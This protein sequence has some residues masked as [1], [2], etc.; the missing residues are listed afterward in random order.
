M[1]SGYGFEFRVHILHAI[2]QGKAAYLILLDRSG[3]FDTIDLEILLK[4][5]ETHLGIGGTVL[6][7]FM[8]Y[9]CN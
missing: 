4:Y 7:W 2:H 9:L 8:S 1:I 6:N 5:M 3:A